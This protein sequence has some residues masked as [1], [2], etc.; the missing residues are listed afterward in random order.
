VTVA[1]RRRVNQELISGV[2]REDAKAFSDLYDRCLE[3][4]KRNAHHIPSFLEQ[5]PDDFAGDVFVALVR[6]ECVALRR[7]RDPAALRAYIKEVFL[8]LVRAQIK[9]QPTP[10]LVPLEELSPREEPYLS[11]EEIEVVRIATTEVLARLP[12]KQRVAYILWL[13]GT[14]YEE[15]ADIVGVP[16]G[17]VGTYIHRT[18]E[19][20][21]RELG[22]DT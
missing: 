15:I 3:V 4:V 20:L 18:N 10:P 19:K 16:I 1:E 13:E 14:S 17:T 22:G 9:K 2:L 5:E 12:A 6:D 11:M 7:L 8:N 21:R